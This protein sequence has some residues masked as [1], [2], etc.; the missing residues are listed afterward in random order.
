MARHDG[1]TDT[2]TTGKLGTWAVCI[3]AAQTS[4]LADGSVQFLSENTDSVIL[5][6]LAA[7][8][9]GEIVDHR[10]F[11]K[12]PSYIM[13][14]HKSRHCMVRADSCGC[15]LRRKHFGPAEVDA[16]RGHRHSGWQAAFRAVVAFVPTG[17]TH[18]TGANGYTDKA[19]KYE[20][21]TRR[22]ERVRRWANI[23]W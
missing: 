17:S 7:M 4:V 11:K 8:A 10:E 14:I 22:E 18:G 6:Q 2:R 20:L 13:R 12:S 1:H 3:R 16:G 5:E 19:G 9:D 15:R 21:A 23:A